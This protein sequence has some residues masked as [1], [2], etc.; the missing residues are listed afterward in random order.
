MDIQSTGH[1]AGSK[2]I[3][4]SHNSQSS[5]IDMTQ[6]IVGAYAGGARE[7]SLYPIA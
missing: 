4:T 5:L 1:G 6:H 3:L 7:D 2:R